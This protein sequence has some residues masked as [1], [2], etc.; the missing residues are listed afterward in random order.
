MRP[1]GRSKMLLVHNG[2]R[3]VL[4]SAPA[5][6]K[7]GNGDPGRRALIADYYASVL[8]AL[9]THHQGEEMV[10][11]PL[12]IE[13]APEE[14]GTVDLAIEQHH[15]V[16]SALAAA[17]TSVAS[18]GA[19]GDDEADDVVK[20][21]AALNEALSPHLDHEEAVIVP[22]LED[23]MT[24]EDWGMLEAGVRAKLPEFAE[25]LL[26][27]SHGMS[28]LWDAVGEKAFLEMVT[29]VG[30]DFGL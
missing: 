20:T 30:E 22:L 14:W 9:E 11:F 3:A 5:L 6:I 18:W 16:V 29:N 28:L 2:F 19:K 13:R 7:C 4:A 8:A 17:K 21:L 24:L 15:E 23:H 27:I 1:I 12:L 25:I 26:S 10:L